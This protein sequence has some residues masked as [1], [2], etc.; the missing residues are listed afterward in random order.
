MLC[1]WYFLDISLFRW[2]LSPL[3]VAANELQLPRLLKA[4]TLESR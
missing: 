2:L 4:G 1:L 3:C